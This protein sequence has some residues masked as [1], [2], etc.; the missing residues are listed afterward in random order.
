[1]SYG[2]SASK[3]RAAPEMEAPQTETQERRASRRRPLDEVPQ[4]VE[5]K[6]DSSTVRV[7]DIS[8]GGLC[9]QLPERLAPGNG[10]RLQIVAEKSTLMIRCRILRCQVKS[11]GVGSLVYEA[12]GKFEKPLALVADDQHAGAHGAEPAASGKHLWW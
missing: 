3:R 6:T 12:A 1:M 10:I 11:L 8:S 7:V 9:M 2:F 4:I 5:V